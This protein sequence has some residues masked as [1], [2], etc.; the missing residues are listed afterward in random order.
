M[1][2]KNTSVRL[3]GSI[4]QSLADE[5][6]GKESRTMKR[7]KYVKIFMLLI[8]QWI[9]I[10]VFSLVHDISFFLSLSIPLNANDSP[11]LI[12]INIGI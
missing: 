7:T 12:S 2:S 8:I 11:D 1:R 10:D 3:N 6:E 5:G 9:L 4:S